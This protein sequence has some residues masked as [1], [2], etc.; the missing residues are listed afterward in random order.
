M[1]NFF[2]KKEDS[3]PPAPLASTLSGSHGNPQS[4]GS[5]SS[6]SSV[7]SNGSS[8]QRQTFAGTSSFTLPQQ[9]PTPPL[10]ARGSLGALP[11]IKQ[12]I[13]P[14]DA[15]TPPPTMPR[16]GVSVAGQPPVAARPAAP[17]ASD[18]YIDPNEDQDN[19][20]APP[21]EALLKRS[22]NYPQQHAPPAFPS[23]GGPPPQTVPQAQ[24]PAVAAAGGAASS[25][26][27]DPWDSTA[28]ANDLYDAPDDDQ[29]AKLRNSAA[30]A[31][32][33]QPAALPSQ[34]AAA[35]A[36]ARPG[37][38]DYDDPWDAAAPA[39][40]VRG[41]V[42][43]TQPLPPHSAASANKG[44][45]P[46]K[47]SKAATTESSSDYDDPW[48]AQT[49]AQPHA[50]APV[51]ARAAPTTAANSDYD[52]PWDA[53]PTLNLGRGNPAPVPSHAAAPR[54]AAQAPAPAAAN[55]DYDDPWDAQPQPQQPQQPSAVVRGPVPAPPRSFVPAAAGAGGIRRPSPGPQSPV[56]TPVAPR[57]GPSPTAQQPPRFPAAPTPANPSDNYIQDFNEP[58]PRVPQNQGRPA[59]NP[60][61]PITTRPSTVGRAGAAALAAAAATQAPPPLPAGGPPGTVG[62][63]GMPG[64]VGRA[65]SQ[66]FAPPVPVSSRPSLPTFNNAP[67]P[68]DSLESQLWFHGAINRNQ[69]H[70]L[71]ISRPD[72]SFLVRASESK[73]NEC[74]LS[75]KNG[76][77]VIH[78]RIKPRPD[79]TY[80]LG[81]HSKPFDT[82]PLMIAHYSQHRLNIKGAEH[83]VLNN[84]VLV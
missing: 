38:D 16:S 8:N 54:Q 19:Y 50:P 60:P 44:P 30:V 56:S 61:P 24:R 23:R 84:P 46:P 82:V 68:Q 71:L 63:S 25:D 52:D 33:A 17:P 57:G 76:A 27:D 26:Y 81:E 64:S 73:S 40:P 41:G 43:G 69:A 83:I 5:S 10:D 36:A 22:P 67:G 77:D 79:N 39:V 3:G 48:D 21:R 6:G 32:K 9:Q 45:K 35:A 66:N 78:M 15:G 58:P 14:S 4:P 65:G 12:P 74:S 18:L 34:P 20:I 49:P 53:Q 13:R 42:I 47:P 75:I 70:S 37:G 2:R 31:R 7:G 11:G 1:V 55:S 62:R 59:A 28:P 29:R 72:G 80:I 51:A